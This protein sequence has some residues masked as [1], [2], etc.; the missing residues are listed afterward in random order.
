MREREYVHPHDP[1]IWVI[2][3]LD[4]QGRFVRTRNIWI[5]VPKLI[6]EFR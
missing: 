6:A 5:P 1:R 3:T 2:D 4:A